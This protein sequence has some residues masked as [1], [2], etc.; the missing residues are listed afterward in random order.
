MKVLLV[1]YKNPAFWAVTDYVEMALAEMGHQVFFFDYRS[2]RV[3]GR[4]RARV[5]ALD[6]WDLRALN[7]RLRSRI[8]QVG[9]DIFLVLGGHTLALRN[10]PGCE[11]RV[12]HR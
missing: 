5:R 1:G 10:T 3:P 4:L 8:G 9:P 11:D 7:R 2:F 12:R 6:A